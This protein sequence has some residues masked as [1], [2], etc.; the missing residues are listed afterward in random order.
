[1]IKLFPQKVYKLSKAKFSHFDRTRGDK[2]QIFPTK[3]KFGFT[4]KA[5]KFEKIFVILTFDKSVVF[6]APNSVLVKK[7]TKIFQ[8]KY[9][10]VVLYK[11]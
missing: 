5:K 8:N 10:L 4:E 9:G 3:V 11:L 6:C 1:M 7:S 2:S